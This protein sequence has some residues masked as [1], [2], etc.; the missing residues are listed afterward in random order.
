MTIPVVGEMAVF[1]PELRD[2]CADLDGGCIRD[3]LLKMPSM[4]DQKPT[5]EYGRGKPLPFWKQPLS[6]KQVALFALPTFI[7]A[8]LLII[9][10]IAVHIFGP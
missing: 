7:V 3:G 5:L 4:P 2:Y 8:C 6:W 9:A 1:F 10:W